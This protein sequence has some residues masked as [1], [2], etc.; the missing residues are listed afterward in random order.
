[1]FEPSMPWNS[2]LKVAAGDTEFWDLELKEPALLYSRGH[3]AAAPSYVHAQPE[4]GQ[5]SNKRGRKRNAPTEHPPTASGSTGRTSKGKGSKSKGSGTEVCFSWNQD[6]M[7]CQDPCPNGRAHSCEI[8][9]KQH[10][11]VHCT[12]KGGPKGKRYAST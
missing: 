1:M 7:G 2:V 5:G 3:G 12:A 11:K 4:A 10:R 9:G 6:P 8:C